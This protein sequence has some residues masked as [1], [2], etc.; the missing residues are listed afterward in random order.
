MKVLLS[1]SF[2]QFRIF[3]KES[4][5]NMSIH[6]P[7][8]SFTYPSTHSYLHLIYTINHSI[9]HQCAHPLMQ[10]IH[11]AVQQC[12]IY[13]PTIFQPTTCWCTHSR[14]DH[15]TNHQLIHISTSES[16]C[17]CPHLLV[18]PIIPRFAHPSTHPSI[19]LSSHPKHNP[20]HTIHMPNHPFNIH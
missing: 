12:D 19:H 14:T 4:T 8:Y 17:P 11:T 3:P 7:I 2:P 1:L 18:Q 5:P 13:N 9:T 10:A 15:P 16:I 6:T 20:P